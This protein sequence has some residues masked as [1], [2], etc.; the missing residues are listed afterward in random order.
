[1]TEPLETFMVEAALLHYAGKE[2]GEPYWYMWDT[3]NRTGEEYDIPGLGKVTIVASNLPKDIN[4]AEH[5][6]DVWLV[7]KVG[8]FYYRKSG[9]HTSYVG[10]E[11]EDGMQLVNPK[12]VE[13]TIYEEA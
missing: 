7:F 12:Q 8:D 4:Y 11:W 10:T 1:M 13:I 5:Y 9:S 2:W 3:S 6:E